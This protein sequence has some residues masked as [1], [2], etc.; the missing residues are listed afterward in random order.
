M[1]PLIAVPL[2]IAFSM[3][4]ND[5]TKVAIPLVLGTSFATLGA[6]FIYLRHY[7][8]KPTSPPIVCPKCGSA[9]PATNDVFCARCGSKLTQTV[10]PEALPIEAAPESKR[11]RRTPH[12]R[13]GEK[14]CT[15]CGLTIEP[16]DTL[17]WC[18]HCGNVAHKDH[19]VNWVRAKKRCPI[20]SS[21][22]DERSL[23]N[24]A[25]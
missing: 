20:C 15:V 23:L 4:I 21:T 6:V 8:L 1:A 9:L 11:T 18:P 19:L 12:K 22:L 24:K 5:A 2:L 14:V 17:A 16:N 10:E 13:A 7:E 25:P 3:G